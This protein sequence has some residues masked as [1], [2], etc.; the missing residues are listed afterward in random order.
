VAAAALALMMVVLPACGG[1]SSGGGGNAPTNVPPAPVRSLIGNFNFTVVG[2]P[3]A[4]RLG[5]QRDFFLQQLTITQAG[6]LEVIVDWTFASN[7]IDIVLFS[8]TCTPALIT[9]TG[10][11]AITATTSVTAKPERLTSNVNPG[12]YTIG[13]T[14]FGNGNESGVGQVFLTR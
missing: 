1:G 13:V 3:E 9:S 5:L 12:S 11:S 10:C 8:G 2:V 6:S 7:D 14:N 4:N